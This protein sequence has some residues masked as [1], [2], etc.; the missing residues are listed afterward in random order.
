VPQNLLFFGGSY[1]WGG[2]IEGRAFFSAPL[3][4]KRGRKLKYRGEGGNNFRGSKEKKGVLIER[5]ERKRL[6]KTNRGVFVK[7][8]R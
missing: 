8:V 7:A 1:N 6:L 3:H 4:K 5:G 2:R